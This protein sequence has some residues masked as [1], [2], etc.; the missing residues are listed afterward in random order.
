MGIRL[1]SVG[2]GFLALG[3]AAIGCE[4]TEESATRSGLT[5]EQ[6]EN[7]VRRSYQYVAMYNVNNKFALKLGGWNACD[8]DTRL[9]DHTMREIARPNNDTLYISCLLDLRKDPVIL[10]IP[11]FGSDYTSLMVTA[12]DHYV[13]VPLSTIKG[14]FQRPEKMLFYS[15]RTDGYRG[16]PVDGVDRV[17][18][19][20]GDFVSAVFRVMPHAG[21]PERF[22]KIVDRMKQVRLTLSQHRGGQA[23]PIGDITFP[24]VGT[25][26]ADVFGTNL[27]DVMQFVFDHTTFDPNDA[28]DQGVLAAWKPLGVEPGK[29]RDPEA[30]PL[31]GA[32]VR[33]VAERIAR[34]EL[35]G[36]GAMKENALRLFHPK[37][38]MDLD[39]L[40][41]QSVIGPI[42]LPASEAVY[43]AITTADGA[44]MSARNDYVIRM[45][46][47]EMPPAKAFWSITLY[48]LKNGFFI[49]N[50]RKK[51]SVGRNAGMKLDANGGI[52]VY[53]AAEKP[54]GVPEE[55]WL[56]I[57]RKDEDMNVIM[58]L[59]APDLERFKTWTP[60]QAEKVVAGSK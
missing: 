35:A 6:L 1:S 18:E 17:F 22:R 57:E 9:K 46:P 48:D 40:L 56:P 60:P 59:Y 13:N 30:V 45:S 34:A 2:V 4:R 42:G 7:L 53:V 19:T 51:Y 38:Q 39:M 49:P 16:E 14:D 26:D 24:P 29:A 41:F 23:K 54:R 52:A 20:S 15:A 58:R 10:D 55:N 50:D 32:R 44:P 25:T 28:I 27:A 3:I 8:A 21:E 31:D 5:D 47:D 36:A 33:Q 43:P 12:Y 11:V 37:G